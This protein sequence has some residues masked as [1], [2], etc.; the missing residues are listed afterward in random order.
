VAVARA[1]IARLDDRVTPT[2][3][4]SNDPAELD[5]DLV[6]HWLS[7]DAYWAI[8]RSRATHDAAVAGSRNYGVF[9]GDR[10]DNSGAQLGYA[11]II[12]DGATFAWLCDVY[13]APDARGR[14]AGQLLLT[15][16]LAELDPLGLKRIGL[17]TLDAHTLYEKFGFQALDEPETWMDRVPPTAIP[18]PAVG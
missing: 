7:E 2:L 1:S 13:V 16:I 12:T 10:G 9:D 14:G 8:G 5:L 17:R 11:R 15:G 3:R 6:F 18:S 4:F